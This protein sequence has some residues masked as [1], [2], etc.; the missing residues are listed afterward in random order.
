MEIILTSKTKALR[1]WRK[2]KWDGCKHSSCSRSFKLID[3]GFGKVWFLFSQWLGVTNIYW[4][5][6]N[7]PYSTL[8]CTKQPN[9]T[10]NW[11]FHKMWIVPYWGTMANGYVL[12]THRNMKNQDLGDF[13]FC[14]FYITED[15]SEWILV[16]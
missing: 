10:K 13:L 1:R 2:R 7:N 8:E 12:F 5:E 15:N 16:N 3:T 11:T 14:S 4:L 6:C 9:T